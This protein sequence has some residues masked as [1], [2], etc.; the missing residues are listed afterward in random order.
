[1]VFVEG[2]LFGTHRLVG[3]PG[4]RHHHHHGV[5]QGSARQGHQF[6]G[7]IEDAGVAAVLV[8]HGLGA[9]QVVAKQV[10]L[11]HRLTGIHPV[12][13]AAQGVDFAIVGDVAVGVGT[14]PTG[15]GV[16]AKAGMHQG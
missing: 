16:G 13:V 12:D 6:Q 3:R 5:G 2:F 1:M 15:E 11:K 4:F 8:N 10:G 9:S 7:V 14:L